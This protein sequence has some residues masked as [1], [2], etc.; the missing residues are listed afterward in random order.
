MKVLHKLS[1]KVKPLTD[2]YVFDTENGERNGKRVKYN[3]NKEFI[4]GVIYGYNYTKV[5]HNKKEFIETLLE[6]RF[7]N[8]ILFAHNAQYD[9]TIIYGNIFKFDPSAIFN[10]NFICATNGNCRFA[11]SMNI[12]V[13]KKVEHIGKQLGRPKLDIL[14]D[15]WYDDVTEQHIN[16]CIRDCEI[17]WD[18]LFM[19]FE[20]AGDIKITQASLSMT[21]FRRF[22]LQFNIKHNENTKY[23]W[24]SYYGGRTEAFIK[25]ATHAHV[26]DVNSM[27]PYC[28]KVEK[29]PN[30]ER[31]KVENHVDLK[32]F[33]KRILYNYEGCIYA[34][35]RH[36]QSTY[37]FLPYK[38]NG[39]LLFPIGVF[40]GCWNFN[41]IRFALEQGAITIE[42]V[43]RICYAPAM[44]SSPL[45]KFVDHLYLE[46]FRLNTDFEID[47]VKR[48]MNSLYGKFA[49]RVTEEHIYIENIEKQYHVIQDHQRNNTFI[50]FVPFNSE[51]LD[52]FIVVKTTKKIDTSFSIPSFA[53]YITSGARVILLKELLRI[54]H[55]KP[56][57]CDTD[58]IFFEI[59]EGYN[60]SKE[61][62]KFKLEGAHDKEGNFYPK[63][64][65]EIRGLKNYKYKYFDAKENKYVD[66]HRLKGVPKTAIKVGENSYEYF[67]LTKTKESLRRNIEAGERVKRTKE[68]SNKYDK[69][70]VLENGETKPIE[71]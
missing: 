34:T 29:F 46:R 70:I 7:K 52:G 15:H 11:C 42:K 13:G 55:L 35:I 22:H 62:G 3:F 40:S 30:P 28:M 68:I 36:K 50:R 61:L 10:G 37:G 44:E 64:V 16:Y 45:A 33:L 6:P 54:E 31:L 57:Y 69:R 47:R 19:T 51:R 58:S 14:Y 60:S 63:I 65:T 48:F 21:Y 49:Q 56:V 24:D 39:K 59:Y 20:F 26:I 12:F 2:F 43:N 25:R 8:K 66:G 71:L 9:L 1:P 38:D 53:S 5:I 17:V 67:N 27:Y 4:F 41:E 18:A 23:F 32:Y